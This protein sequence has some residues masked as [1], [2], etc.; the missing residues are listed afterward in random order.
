MP[1]A[2]RGPGRTS[3][4]R[5]GGSLWVLFGRACRPILLLGVT[6]CALVGALTTPPYVVLVI[7]TIFGIFVAGGVAILSVG[8]VDMLSARRT[9]L[10][11]GAWAALLVP[12]AAGV[13]ALG[14][15]GGGVAVALMGL[16]VVVVSSWIAETCDPSDWAETGMDV[17]QL[18]QFIHVLPTSMLLREWR[19]TGEHLQPGADLYRRA[20]AVQVRTLLM[21]ELS[22]R[23]PVG[24]GRWLSEGDEDAPER[25]VRGDWS[26]SP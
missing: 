19:A 1:D 20:Q 24:V 10:L 9:I 11:S 15:A 2:G 5:P 16:C 14:P 23:D 21:E 7:S 17:D 4:S 12:A 3:V 8:L 22:R 25:Y 13:G 6:G 26:A 18:Q